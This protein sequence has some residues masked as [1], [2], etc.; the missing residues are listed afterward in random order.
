ML[1][2]LNNFIMEDS[3]GKVSEE[4]LKR[5]ENRIKSFSIWKKEETI[6][7]GFTVKNGS[8]LFLDEDALIVGVSQG[9]LVDGKIPV[10]FK[11]MDESLMLHRMERNPMTTH[12]LWKSAEC[13]LC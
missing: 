10:Y 2:N 1:R 3:D 5:V 6:L 11:C 12:A 7:D 8:I 9:R 4:E 13:R